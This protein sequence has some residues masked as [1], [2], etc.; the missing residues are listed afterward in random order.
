MFLPNQVNTLRY[1]I[2][3]YESDGNKTVINREMSLPSETLGTVS[4]SLQFNDWIEVYYR[5]QQSCW[6]VE[7]LKHT[8]PV[9]ISFREF[10]KILIFDDGITV[11]DAIEVNKYI[12]FSFN[13]YKDVIGIDRRRPR[14]T[15]KTYL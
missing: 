11:T 6:L 8:I 12:L 5:V 9:Q 13:V 7:G 1:A 15:T 4:T 3:I 10:S 14:N 2:S